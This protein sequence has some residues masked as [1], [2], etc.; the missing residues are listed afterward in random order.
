V[1]K[2]SIELS[3]S[4]FSTGSGINTAFPLGAK[5][6]TGSEN[7]QKPPHPPLIL[8]PNQAET[9]SHKNLVK[10]LT[11]AGGGYK[12]QRKMMYARNHLLDFGPVGAKDDHLQIPFEWVGWSSYCLVAIIPL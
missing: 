8:G 1:T 4:L 11:S 10:S 5:G 3:D 12:G 2:P 6:E 9:N 7:L